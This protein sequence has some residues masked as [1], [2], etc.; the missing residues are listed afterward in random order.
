MI[1]GIFISGLFA[2]IYVVTAPI[3][4]LPDV[5]STSFGVSQIATISGWVSSAVAILPMT[6]LFIII[7]LML[8]IENHVILYRA[9][10]WVITKIPGVS[11]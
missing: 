1:P 2:I 5:T 8:A 7:G 3:R 4:L 10:M 6:Q 11:N 9:L